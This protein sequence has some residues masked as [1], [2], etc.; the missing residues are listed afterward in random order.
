MRVSAQEDPEQGKTEDVRDARSI[1]N[2]KNAGRNRKAGVAP[3][4]SETHSTSITGRKKKKTQKLMVND[5]L[6]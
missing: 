3:E 4:R 1:I 2:G 6:S 5:G